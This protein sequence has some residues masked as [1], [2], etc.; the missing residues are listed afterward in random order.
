MNSISKEIALVLRDDPVAW[1]GIVMAEVLIP[2]TPNVYGDFWTKEAIREAAYMF[3]VEGFGIDIN[4]DQIDISDRVSV[5]ESFVVRPGDAIF[6]EGSWVL[7]LKVHDDALWQDILDCKINGYSYMAYVATQS[8]AV[9][10]EDDGMRMGVTEPDTTDGHTHE[11]MVLVDE[12]NRP[13][14]G[15]TTNTSGH[16]HAILVHTVTEEAVGHVHRYNLVT[17][18]DGK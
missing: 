5:V 12:N 8:A 13:I 17:G 9:V 1:E 15:G 18:K 10:M 2:D 7:A 4:H 3:M 6:I 11:Y 14:S 16:S